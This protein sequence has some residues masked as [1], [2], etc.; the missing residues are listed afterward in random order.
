MLPEQP[1]GIPWVTS[2]VGAGG[3]FGGGLGGKGWAEGMAVPGLEGTLTCP[4]F[5]LT[6]RG[7]TGVLTLIED[8]VGPPDWGSLRSPG[9][10][11]C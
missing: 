6:T 4:W 7:A 5:A 9:L 10:R 11:F 3:D 8:G 2:G 1:M